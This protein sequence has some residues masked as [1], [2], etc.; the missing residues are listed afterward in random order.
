MEY[1]ISQNIIAAAYLTG[2]AEALKK[3]LVI[4]HED[5]EKNIEDLKPLRRIF[6]DKAETDGYKEPNNHIYSA[7]LNAYKLLKTTTQFPNPQPTLAQNLQVKEEPT[8]QSLDQTTP[9]SQTQYSM[10]QP[11]SSLGQSTVQPMNSFGQSSTQPMNSMG[12][13]STQPMNSIGQSSL[14]PSSTQPM[15]SLGQ[16]SLGPSS[17]QPMNSFG[18]SSLGPSSTQPMNSMGQSSTQPMNS[19]GQSS[20]QP[21]NSLGQIGTQPINSMGQNSLAQPTPTDQNS[22][23]PKITTTELSP[24]VLS[25]L[26]PTLEPDQPDKDKLPTVV[27]LGGAK[28]TRKRKIYRRKTAVKVNRK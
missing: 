13:S 21:I 27:Q 25:Q 23:L 19:F 3:S 16:S 12:Q 17:T 8:S 5:V 2:A 14:G 24:P 6:L 22:S 4:G 15:N 26:P 7:K 10:Q 20:T 9:P 18:Q 1:P 28:K 11:E